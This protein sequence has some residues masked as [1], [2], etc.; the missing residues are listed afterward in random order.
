M[1]WH[2]PLLVH[3][4]LLIGMVKVSLMGLSLLMLA[5]LKDCLC[6][7]ITM[8]SWR[9]HISRYWCIH[10]IW[11]S[12]L[13]QWI[14]QRGSERSSSSATADTIRELFVYNPRR[15]WCGRFWCVLIFCTASIRIGICA[16]IFVSKSPS[17]SVFVRLL[18]SRNSCRCGRCSAR[19]SWSFARST[20]CSSGSFWSFIS[21][22]VVSCKKKK[23]I[24]WSD[25]WIHSQFYTL[26]FFRV[27]S[28]IP[29]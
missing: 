7:L 9:S 25:Q 24:L 22:N 26:Y 6:S 27:V 5:M 18:I 19:H 20:V 12:S 10:L 8:C 13:S 23:K 1:C 4:L 15:R 17:L 21:T 16:S 14:W 11:I 29:I 2:S 28:S 3:K